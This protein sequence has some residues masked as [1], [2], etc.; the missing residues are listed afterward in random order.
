MPPHR[1]RG[2]GIRRFLVRPLVKRVAAF[3]R[4]VERSASAVQKGGTFQS[5]LAG[6]DACLSEKDARLAEKDSF[7]KSVTGEKDARLAEKDA[8]LA[9]KDARLAEKDVRLAEKDVRL[10]EKDAA[11]AKLEAAMSRDLAS[12]LHAADMA[13]GVAGSRALFEACMMVLWQQAHAELREQPPEASMTER[14]RKLLR[15]PFD[16]GKFPGLPSALTVAAEDNGVPSME[17]VSQARRMYEM[18]SARVHAEEVGGTAAL[19]AELFAAAGR[20]ALVAFAAIVRAAGRELSLYGLGRMQ[21]PLRLRA[22]V[23]STATVEQARAAP[24]QPEVLV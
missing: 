19:P 8:R 3:S 14:V 24:M 21:M 10:A 7:F 12:A 22:R 20:P 6:K 23:S 1:T 16:G 11:F 13:R 2:G 18:L 9:E 15:A 17:V 4:I 5:L